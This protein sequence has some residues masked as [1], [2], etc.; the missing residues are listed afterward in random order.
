MRSVVLLRPSEGLYSKVF[1]PWIP[2]S[3]LAAAAKL[4]EAGYPIVLIDQRTSSDWKSELYHALKQ[5]PICVGVTAMTGSQITHA[6]EM[7]ACVKQ[8]SSTPVVW[9]GVHATLFPSQTLEHPCIDVV[10]KGEGE[11]TFLQLILRI[12]HGQSLQNLEG[13]AYKD[14]GL[15]VHNPERPFLDLNTLPPVPYHLVHIPQYLHRYFDNKR[16]LEVETSRGCPFN[17]T[18]CYNPLYAKRQWRALNAPRLLGLLQPLVETYGVKAFHFVDDG[19]FIDKERTREIMTG[20]LKQRWSIKMG[21]QG[22]RVDTI[23]QMTDADLDLVVEAGGVFLQV[24]VESGS[25][26]ILEILNK[27]IHPDQVVAFNRRLSRYPQM[28]VYY[29]FMCGFPSETRDDVLRTTALAWSLLRDNPNALISAFHFYKPYPGTRLR[30]RIIHQDDVT[31]STLEGWGTFNWTQYIGRDQDDETRKLME[32]IETVS[33][34]VDQ[35][36]NYQ[37]DSWIMK[38]LADMYRPVARFRFKHHWYA[39][40]PEHFLRRW[41][42]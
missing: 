34:F 21:F 10:V 2:L 25:P 42:E 36:M 6:L 29:N 26:R 13:I 31:P 24:G 18:F 8:H 16:V 41:M 17:C 19:F 14:H 32:R 27:R 7:S 15:I 38:M 30:E 39:W 5:N 1:R 20:V 9:G 3:L 33:I 23:D 12:E 35:K 37:S 40:M 11:E 4:D 22:A 28:K